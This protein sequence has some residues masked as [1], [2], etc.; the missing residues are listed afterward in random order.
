MLENIFGGRRSDC[1]TSGAY[2]MFCQPEDAAA[3][4]TVDLEATWLRSSDGVEGEQLETAIA[5]ISMNEGATVDW[6]AEA[7]WRMPWGEFPIPAQRAAETIRANSSGLWLLQG[8]R[9]EAGAAALFYFHRQCPGKMREILL[10]KDF[11]EL[12]LG[13]SSQNQLR[14][15]TYE[16]GEQLSNRLTSGE[17]PWQ[18]QISLKRELV[19]AKGW[20]KLVQAPYVALEASV[21]E[22]TT[23]R[24]NQDTHVFRITGE[25]RRALTPPADS[26]EVDE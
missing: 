5:G 8:L 21:R 20:R 19:R 9:A 17:L 7:K 25:D 22:L 14:I 2:V 18:A 10:G 16:H 12:T 26:P 6:T 23:A 4:L 24:A 11:S 15:C 1:S 13:V 3:Y